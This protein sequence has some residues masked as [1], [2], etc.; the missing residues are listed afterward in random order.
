MSATDPESGVSV[1]AISA[2]EASLPNR[3]T[4]ALL[5]IFVGLAVATIWFVVLPALTGSRPATGTCASFV[6][7]S[8]GDAQC[9]DQPAP[10]APDAPAQFPVP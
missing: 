9:I 5:I 6:V 2:G 4:H 7:A 1:V 8:S 10:V 3:A